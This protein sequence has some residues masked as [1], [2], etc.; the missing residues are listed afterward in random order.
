MGTRFEPIPL[1]QAY[2]RFLKRDDAG[3]QARTRHQNAQALALESRVRRE[4]RLQ[5]DIRE[6]SALTQMIFEQAFNCAQAESSRFYGE[7]AA[8]HPEME[9]RRL[10]GRVYDPMV[11]LAKAWRD[12]VADF[13]HRLETDTM[14]RD[15]RIDWVVD[16]LRKSI[17]A[18]T[19]ADEKEPTA[20]P[21]KRKAKG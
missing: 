3:R 21:A 14:K 11:S 7:M 17:T 4:L 19:A 20:R 13:L 8:I 12:G 2:L 10:T 6:V 1:M 18:K 5:L 9:A 16:E 15:D